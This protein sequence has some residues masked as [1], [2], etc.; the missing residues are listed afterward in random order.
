[1]LLESAT[2]HALRHT[3]GTLA[4]AKGMP[5]DVVQGVLGHASGTTTSIYVRAKE[6]RTMEVA[7]QYFAQL[8][9]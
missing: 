9:E 4:V 1:M 3:F 6:K 5:Q 8:V 7:S 2:P